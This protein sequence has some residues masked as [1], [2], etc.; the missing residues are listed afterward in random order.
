MFK[1]TYEE[2][3]YECKKDETILEALM[4]Q[5]R[6]IRFSCKKGTCKTCKSKVLEG[7]IPDGAHGQL[8]EYLIENHLIL[9]CVTHPI[10]DM[11]LVAPTREDLI[12]KPQQESPYE[13]REE[14]KWEHPQPDAELWSAL[15]EGELMLEIITDFYT[16]VYQDPKLA[17]FFKSTS[18]DR[19]IGKQ[20]N[21]L[22]EII[23]GEPVYFGFYP[24]TAHHWM[25]IDE[26]L[27]KYREDLL[28]E[29]MLTCGLAPDMAKKWRALDEH[30]KA[31]IIKSRPWPKIIGDVL[32][33]LAGFDIMDADFDML[34]DV[35][36]TEIPMGTKFR[37]HQDEGTVYCHGCAML[38]ANP[39]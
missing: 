3:T 8:E 20:F 34:C 1:I 33:P 10:S 5:G 31:M 4:R 24:R 25:V 26:E 18:I 23:S 30:Y 37:Y 12:K 27:F 32:V 39:H 6:E 11:T 22:K 14:E 17:P 15:H 29:S 36:Q 2:S 38:E 16:K 21:F 35:C 13:F 28:E 7:D 9:P 19:A